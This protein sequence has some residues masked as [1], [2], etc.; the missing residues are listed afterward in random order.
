MDKIGKKYE[1]KNINSIFYLNFPIN[2]T[3]FKVIIEISHFI[4]VCATQHQNEDGIY[5]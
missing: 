3:K 1:Q 2:L 4:K 5:H